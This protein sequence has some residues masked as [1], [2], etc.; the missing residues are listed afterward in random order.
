MSATFTVHT[1][2]DLVA[3]APLVLGFEP[4]ESVMIET[5]GGFAGPFHARVDLPA[6]GD[7]QREVTEI[8]VGAALRNGV[9]QVAVLVYGADASRARAQARRCERA[10]RAA[11]IEVLAVLHVTPER[12]FVVARGTDDREGTPYD[13][14]THP[15]TSQWVLE[16]RVVRS[17]REELAATLRRADPAEVRVVDEAVERLVRDLRA[18]PAGGTAAATGADARWLRGRVRRFLRTGEAPTAVEAARIL[19]LCLDAELRDVLWSGITREDAARHVELWSDLV[20]RAPDDLLPE[21][22]GVLAL[23]AW[24][25]GDG[26]L[27]WCAIERAKEVGAETFLTRHVGEILT[28]AIPPTVWRPI[29]DDE[30]PVLRA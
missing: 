10:L 17:S 23:A 5:F 25:A 8:L 4:T 24:L 16:G 7:A 21:A 11:R 27:A 20:R 13:V 14:S 12:Y 9:T 6:T 22:A 30:L 19:V 1:A 29:P 18:V 26:A 28:A 2:T 15:F 3:L